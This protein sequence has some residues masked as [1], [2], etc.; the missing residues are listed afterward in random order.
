MHVAREAFIAESGGALI[1]KYA[2]L[3]DDLFTE[4]GYRDYADDL[5]E[6]MTNPHLAD[7][8]ARASRDVVRKLGVND[9]IFGTM[10]LALEYGIEPRNMAMGALAGVSLLLANATEYGLPVG[11]APHT[12]LSSSSSERCV[13]RT[14]QELREDN[15]ARLLAKLW[16][17]P[18]SPALQQLV[19]HTCDACGP[20]GE[21]L[22]P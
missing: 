12:D 7:T 18:I 8:T 3:G 13:I 19:D 9:R 20:L 4:S 1:R 2:S 16:Q 14:L 21:V 6:R 17:T 15:L 10:A 22:A 5:L 11:C